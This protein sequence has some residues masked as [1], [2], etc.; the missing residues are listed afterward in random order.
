V[1][2]ECR[3]AYNRYAREV[4]AD[5]DAYFRAHPEERGTHLRKATDLERALPPGWEHLADDRLSASAHVTISLA[6]RARCWRWRPRCER[7]AR[8]GLDW[9]FEA[10]SSLPPSDSPLIPPRF[11]REL[12]PK[13]LDELPWV[14][15]VDSSSRRASW[16]S[17]RGQVRR[18]RD[19]AVELRARSAAVA[20]CSGRVVDRPALLA[21]RQ[22]ADRREDRWRA[23]ACASSLSDGSSRVTLR[24]FRR[25]HGADAMKVSAV[26]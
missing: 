5:Y 13:A 1:H 23:S 22:Q 3:D 6:A 21:C 24:P 10:V 18:G 26:A 15:S 4:D 14:T 19:G 9:L 16:S 20:D 17:A 12:P 8:S 2:A 7:P 11:E 25:P